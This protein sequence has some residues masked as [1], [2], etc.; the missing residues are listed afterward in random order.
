MKISEHKVI[1]IATL[2]LF[3]D[4]IIKNNIIN[5]VLNFGA[6]F[7]LFQN[8]RWMLVFI[9]IAIIGLIAYLY[10]KT[11]NKILR[12]SYILISFGTLSNLIDRIFLGYVID[13]IPFPFWP[14]F[15]L[16]DV[17]IC[18][19]VGLILLNELVLERKQKNKIKKP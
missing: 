10:H 3:I 11:K 2:I 17:M 4:Q 16:G 13:Y 12:Y 9:S 18:F 5:P 15:N 8:Q 1:S 7:G 6:G 19:G 14:T